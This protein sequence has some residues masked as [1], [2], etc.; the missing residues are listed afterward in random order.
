MARDRVTKSIR[1]QPARPFGVAVLLLAILATAACGGRKVSAPPPTRTKQSAPP[2]RP[3][4]APTHPQKEPTANVPDR[5]SPH[6]PE[7]QGVRSISRTI[8][9]TAQI[10]ADGAGPLIRIGVLPAVRN[11]S[12]SSDAKFYLI[13]KSSEQPRRNVVGTI[14]VSLENKSGPHPEARKTFRVQIASLTR[15]VDAEA[16]QRQLEDEGIQPVLMQFNP[17][18]A[19]YR[20]RVGRYETRAE[21]EAA[22]AQLRRQRYPQAMVVQ[23]TVSEVPAGPDRRTALHAANKKVSEQSAAGFL[24][25]PSD[26]ERPIKVNGKPYRGAIETLAN[27]NG[28]VTVVNELALEH[29]LKGV[30]PE[31]LPPRSFPEME[32]LKAQAIAARTYALKHRG[33]FKSEGYDLLASERSQVYGGAAS[34]HPL[35]TQA[36]VE[37]AGL[38]VYAQ[39]ELIDA[40]YTSTCG[41]RTEDYENIFGGRRVSYLRGV[42]CAIDQSA[43]GVQGEI[44]SL[45][46][47]PSAS[48]GEVT[49]LPPEMAL[50]NI[51]GVLGEDALEASYLSKPATRQEVAEW[52]SRTAQILKRK[53]ADANG[54]INASLERLGPFCAYLVDHL[55]SR[56]AA[57]VMLSEA[58]THY[59]LASL[60][61]NSELPAATRRQL[62]FLIQKNILIPFSDNTLRPGQP[63]LRQRALAMLYRTIEAHSALPLESGKLLRAQGDL[64][65]VMNGRDPVEARLAKGL[66]LYQRVGK[67]LLATETLKVVGGEEVRFHR[68]NGMIDYLEVTLGANGVASDRFSRFSQWEKTFTIEEAAKKLRSV[69]KLGRLIDLQPTKFGSSNR[70]TELKVIGTQ[71]EFLLTGMRIRSVLGLR[72][73]L[74]SIAREQSEAG[75]VSKFIFTGRGWGHGVGLCQTGTYGMA[76]AGEKYEAILKK[77]YTGVE[78]RKAY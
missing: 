15:A 7:V 35:S 13:D 56:Q 48:N 1:R 54:T 55:F 30:V 67:E 16:L 26:P 53:P 68:R 60:R 37:T 65:Q 4:G 73:T 51:I 40:L 32:G 44:R 45:A 41:G 28:K 2:K 42:T 77:Y 19:A 33:Q 59:Y 70:V 25:L 43:D 22:A 27:R 31:E 36:I 64:V 3:A 8:P 11:V 72:D 12:I 24:F 63:L 58:D 49:T 47:R 10:A 78:I 52:V 71:G 9:P 17:N 62:A 74:F 66:Y 75:A 18:A 6:P 61:D 50:M 20:I 57:E 38:A 5:R 69:F 46:R 21:A 39:G 23:E 29:Y 14:T 34:E 76:V